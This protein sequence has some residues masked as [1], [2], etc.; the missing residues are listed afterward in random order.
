VSVIRLAAAAA[1]FLIAACGRTAEF[2]DDRTAYPHARDS[3]GGVREI[4][5]GTLTP[6]LA[7]QT[8]RNIDRLFPTRAIIPAETPRALPPSGRMLTKLLV[9][10][11]DSTLS[12][13]QYLEHN[14]VAAVL[15]LHE[16][17]IAY[18][19]YRY[20]NGPRTRWMSMSVAKSV[21]STLIG[22]ALRDGSITS[23]DDA[24]TQYV[25]ALAGSAYDGVTVRQVLT[26]TSGVRWSE[27]YT[28]PTSDRRRL[29]EAQIAQ[30]P[31]GALA[32]MRALPRAAAPG[33]VN[34]YSTG[35][36]QIAGEIVRAAVGRPLADY[37]SDRI[38]TPAGMADTAR[39]WLDSPDGVEIGG[40]GISATLRDYARF[41]QFIL[42]DGIIG[43]DTVLPRGWVRE[44]TAPITLTTG[45]TIDY[46][47]L[48]WP[49]TTESGRRDDAFSAVGIHGQLL[50]VNPAARVV[51]VSWGAH[52]APGGGDDAAEQAFID[53]VV[54]SLR[55]FT[56]RGR[57]AR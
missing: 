8:F 9:P 53:A 55:P 47:Y 45:K 15:V 40:S 21:T 43:T 32:V 39:W 41:G 23:L 56:A 20:G 36:T 51:I 33:S 48:W 16:G 24:V 54:E 52:S 42:D 27:R 19:R 1:C 29:L 50:Y 12:V 37:L 4:Y 30:Q 25:P 26:M 31:G 6:E 14:R 13:E 10:L 5:D 2:V 57:A 22:A 46:G 49:A 44:A 3:I 35:E 38:W 11:G 28:D 7:V 34:T 17:R 18:E